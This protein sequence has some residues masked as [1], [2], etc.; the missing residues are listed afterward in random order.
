MDF[1]GR[2]GKVFGSEEL[3]QTLDSSFR[4]LPSQEKIKIL[5]QIG[6]EEG[7]K[8]LSILLRRIYSD[9][10]A[11]EHELAHVI[12]E[13][14]FMES[15]Y[16]GFD[17]CDSFMRFACYHGVILEAIKQNGQSQKVLE[18]LG[19]G[20]LDLDR[21]RVTVTS[22]IHGI[23]HGMMV[24]NSYN[25]LASYED[26]DKIFFDQTELFFC[27]DGVSMENVVRRQEHADSENSLE[28][29]DPYYPCNGVPQKYQPACVREHLHHARRVFYQ[30]DT[31]KSQN[32]CLY[33]KDPLSR[34]EC[35]GALGN[36]INQEFF[37]SPSK[38]IV[39]CSKVIA[40]YKENCFGVAATQY[41]F[42][43]QF[44]KAEMICNALVEPQRSHCMGSV[45]RA[46]ASL[47]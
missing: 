24:V 35:F 25:L 4:Q 6:K 3:S 16:A 26:C 17:V 28:S 44:D 39:E 5:R 2:I 22:C 37:D 46:K 11:D 47:N 19:Q 38:V 27:Y 7:P 20:C 45:E 33:F 34:R 23:G 40:K 1:R 10:P 18:D 31:V 42:G 13:A 36:A 29:K 41:S 15:G 14:G 8:A 9:E 21:N 30:N 32:Y 12:G 43:R